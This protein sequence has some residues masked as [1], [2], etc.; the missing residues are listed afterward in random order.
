MDII[1]IVLQQGN[2][3]GCGKLLKVQVPSEQVS[4]YGPR[5][6]AFIGELAGMHRNS[7][8]LIQDFCHSVL[9][10]PMSLGALQKVID[11]TSQAIL[12]HYEAIATLA[13]QATVGSI[14]E[15]PWY[16]Q[17][18]LQWLWTL[19]T[20]TVSFYLMHPNRSTKRPFAP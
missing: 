10:I 9:H 8:R 17:N 12:P 4:G 18:A 20:D 11:R 15:T 6:T 2:C 3:A 16:C 1:H 14:D 19:T 7:R 13:R 5:L